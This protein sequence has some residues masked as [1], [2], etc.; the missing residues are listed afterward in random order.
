MANAYSLAVELFTSNSHY[1]YEIQNYLI[2]KALS[3]KIIK[4]CQ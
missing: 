2:L 1:A 3:F 4:S